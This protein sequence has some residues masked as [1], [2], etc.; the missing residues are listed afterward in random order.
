[1]KSIAQLTS[2]DGGR[3]RPTRSVMAVVAGI[4]GLA[5][6]VA[7]CGSSPSSTSGGASASNLS[8]S[9]C[10]RAHG[11]PNFPD[12]NAAGQ[13][14]LSGIDQNSPQVKAALQDCKSQR[15]HGLAQ[16]QEDAAAQHQA[17]EYSHCMRAHGVSSF[18]DPG[19]TGSFS[20][21]GVD[22]NSHT[23]QAALK[24]C[25]KLYNPAYTSI[26]ASSAP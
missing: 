23:T 1:M 7:G 24:A 20:N 3:L 25:R 19:A 17:V 14:N 2:R 11:V 6:V 4:A 9:A 5:V 12:P 26:N 22:Y 15:S 16:Q 10:M 8:Y 13:L 18:P 21:S